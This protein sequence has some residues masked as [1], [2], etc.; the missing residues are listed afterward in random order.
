MR[1]TQSIIIDQTWDTIFNEYGDRYNL[2]NYAFP[3]YLFTTRLYESLRQNNQHDVLFFSREGQFLKKLFDQYLT[4]R[5]EFCGDCLPIKTHYFYGSR[6]SVMAAAM[7]TID[8]EDFAFLFRFFG[9]M[10][11]KSFLTSIG[12][13][14]DQ[15][16]QV[17]QAF[18]KKI[19]K[20]HWRYRT[21][22]TFRQLKQLPI[23]R[24]IYEDNRQKQAAA[25]QVY[26]DSFG[27]NYQ[28]N[29]LA[30]V[31]IGYHGTMQDLLYKFFD[32]K[33]N[34]TGYYIKM[35]SKSM[36][37]NQK[38]GLLSDKNKTNREL[39]GNSI[40]QFNAYHYEQILRA[41]HGRCL[42]Y[43][44]VDGHAKP[45]LD[46]TGDDAV[47]YAQHVK[48]IQD[49][50]MDKFQKIASQALTTKPDVSALCLVYYFYQI[51]RKSK[52][53][54]AWLLGMEDNHHDEFGFVGYPGRLIGQGL[55]RSVYRLRDHL[56]VVNRRHYIMKL[57]RKL[58][59]NHMA[60]QPKLIA[61][62]V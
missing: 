20:F 43:Q 60:G 41:D 55:R 3:L 46:E 26:I 51:K 31:D 10:T 23:F 6:N 37:N 50:I 30:V 4:M 24:E 62:L 54:Y 2:S 47:V 48:M 27:V 12:F 14:H 35:R 32:G 9:F 28:Q 52:F 16:E 34:L 25:L 17:A 21:S 45:I 22:R 42:G 59:K 56:F 18:G 19:N 61:N 29:G 1:K 58:S 36:P 38:Y 33:V 40:N 39:L 13:N 11:T 7:K 8:Q 5:K 15:I 49:Q 44:V 53:D 57:R